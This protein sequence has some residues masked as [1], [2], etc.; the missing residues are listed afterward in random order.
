MTFLSTLFLWFLQSTISASLVILLVLLLRRVLQRWLRPRLLHL[1]WMIVMLRLLL[2]VLP[3]SPASMFNVTGVLIERTAEVAAGLLT[4]R[5]PWGTGAV[6][7][8][9]AA[10]HGELQEQGAMS[11]G[12]GLQHPASG[13]R[14]G[15]R[16]AE[17]P[18]SVQSAQ[19]TGERQSQ[20]SGTPP[21]YVQLASLVWFAGACILL[22]VL[23]VQG[24]RINRARHALRLATD[25]RVL[26]VMETAA[27]GFGISRAVAVYT[28]PGP[29]SPYIAGLFRPWIYV[30]ERVLNEAAVPQ[31]LHII[32]HEL[33]HLRRRD[34]LWNWAGSLILAV[35][36]MNPLVWACIRRMKAD[37]EL[38]C[39]A[40]VLEI[41]GEDEAGPYGM[42]MIEHLKRYA[43]PRNRQDLL[44]FGGSRKRREVERRIRMIAG[45]RKG[46]YKL[47]VAGAAGVL[48]LGSVTLT[49]AVSPAPVTV[50][51]ERLYYEG[52][53]D[54]FNSLKRAVDYAPFRYKV[55]AYIPGE[56]GIEHIIY[57][58]TGDGHPES[59]EAEIQYSRY[60]GSRTVEQGFSLRASSGS[61]ELEAAFERLAEAEIN[62][63]ES[64]SRK[65]EV[66]REPLQLGDQPGYK[67][68]VDQGKWESVSYLWLDGEVVYTL[69]GLGGFSAEDRIAIASS[70]RYPDAE[71]MRS[72][73]Y[74]NPND[75]IEDIYAEEDLRQVPASVGFIPKFPM[76]VPG[77]LQSSR[78]FESQKV[79]FGHPR[80]G[81]DWKTRTFLIDYT[82]SAP[83]DDRKGGIKFVQIK[84]DGIY[85]GIRKSGSFVFSRIDGEA[86]VVEAAALTIGGQEVYRTVPYKTDGPLFPSDADHISYFWEDR[87]ICF[88][89]TMAA[90]IARQEEMVAALMKAP[91][92]ELPEH[93]DR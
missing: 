3:G 55:P 4:A 89:V 56:Y 46:S 23:L 65:V 39:D 71:L 84:D 82:V 79:N 31:L 24:R 91:Y 29:G 51:Q 27:A 14:L 44:Y 45:Y 80:D 76:E 58:S 26:Q 86:N 40:Y 1:L 67:V 63:G 17:D 74:I 43:A 15:E 68:I 2:P 10:V 66:R 35:H 13:D 73:R 50:A 49:S 70:M 12:S 34:M 21:L 7:T 33:A 53:P 28:G 32:A 6:S 11:P 88:Q 16:P 5:V 83:E 60:V 20:A 90:R 75:F 78:A 30:P 52:K 18:G 57:S 25:A 61:G 37:R 22:T 41:L 8:L 36:W 87:G 92:L 54:G 72:P 38:A 59:M 42:T 48:L 93:A 64:F 69:E 9:S 77:L 81:D 62:T 47:S 19:R 85:E